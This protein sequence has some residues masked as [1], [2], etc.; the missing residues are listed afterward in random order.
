MLIF[1][2]TEQSRT[3]AANIPQIRCINWLAIYFCCRL[4]RIRLNFKWDTFLTLGPF[5]LGARSA[6]AIPWRRPCLSCNSLYLFHF[7]YFYFVAQHVRHVSTAE[8]KTK[9]Q[10]EKFKNLRHLVL[11]VE[12]LSVEI[13]K[14]DLQAFT[15]AQ[16]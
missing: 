12:M 11:S 6:E 3:H 1:V 9:G 16:Y 14:R 4:H 7:L 2:N 10:F 15:F 8:I 5:T 13:F